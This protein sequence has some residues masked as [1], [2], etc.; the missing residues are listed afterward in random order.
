M[1]YCN[2]DAFHVST[3]MDNKGVAGPES[4]TAGRGGGGA[5]IPKKKNLTWALERASTF[6]GIVSA[7][8]RSRRAALFNLLYIFFSKTASIRLGSVSGFRFLLFFFLLIALHN[9]PFPQQPLLC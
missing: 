4:R 7:L 3:C 2:T 1:H 6:A 5:W 9:S 8:I